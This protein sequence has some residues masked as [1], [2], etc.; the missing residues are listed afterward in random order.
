MENM[1]NLFSYNSVQFDL[2]RY[3]LTLS[4]GAQ[5]AGLVYFLMTARESAP[6][7]QLSSVLLAA[8]IVSATLILFNQQL[9]WS[10]AFT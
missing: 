4:V 1:K 10:Q 8:V 2:V 6:K 7:C 5:I 9:N 3:I